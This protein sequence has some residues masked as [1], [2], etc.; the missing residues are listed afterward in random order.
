MEAELFDVEIPVAICNARL[1]VVDRWS[2]KIPSDSWVVL[3]HLF[4]QTWVDNNNADG[5]QSTIRFAAG[6]LDYKDGEEE[7]VRQLCRAAAQNMNTGS[8]LD[9]I[10]TGTVRKEKHSLPADSQ[11]LTTTNHLVA[12]AAYL[13]DLVYIVRLSKQGEID[14]SKDV[15]FGKPLRCAVS[16]GHFDLVTFMLDHSVD[17]NQAGLEPGWAGLE[18]RCGITA[19]SEA[20]FTGR[21]GL[22]RLILSPVYGCSVLGVKYD[23]AILRAAAGGHLKT[24]QLL[25]RHVNMVPSSRLLDCILVEAAT[26]GHEKT[27]QYALQIRAN[28][29]T[30]EPCTS[31]PSPLQAAARSGYAEV[32]KILLDHGAT[33]WHMYWPQGII[34]ET[35]RRGN[36]RTLQVLQ[37]SGV[38]H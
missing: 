20:A 11:K 3:E 7:C 34:R 23:L 38:W 21:E 4:R 18:M 29:S 16:Q 30:R 1:L 27:V 17:V 10:Q 19:L 15:Y 14:S 13:G 31:Y 5:L 22:V 32:M 28:P 2:Y 26:N 8:I 36:K 24:V 6:V 25:M 33:H 35:Q 12:A 37:E 9:H